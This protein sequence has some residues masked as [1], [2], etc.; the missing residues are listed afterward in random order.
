MNVTWKNICK[1]NTEYSADSVEWC[2]VEP[3]KNVLVCGTYELAESD[4][5]IFFCCSPTDLNISFNPL[6]ELTK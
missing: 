6:P 5:G 4:E 2:P 3:H 1:W